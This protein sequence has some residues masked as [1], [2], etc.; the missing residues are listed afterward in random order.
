M[1]QIGETLRWYGVTGC[2]RAVK[3]SGMWSENGRAA[4]IGILV[5]LMCLLW[6]PS[7]IQQQHYLHVPAPASA[8]A[9]AAQ[10][11]DRGLRALPVGDLR[12]LLNV[13]QSL[14]RWD[15]VV[16]ILSILR[17][18]NLTTAADEALQRD[19]TLVLNVSSVA[20]SKLC[21]T[22]KLLYRRLRFGIEIGD[23]S[24]TRCL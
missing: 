1:K 23:E 5:G 21:V 24:F 3:N 7:H 19:A 6:A 2:V 16:H 14:A 17:E 8:A 4:G 22:I 15:R 13:Q 10:L 9:A 20:V 11:S 18:Q 12:Q